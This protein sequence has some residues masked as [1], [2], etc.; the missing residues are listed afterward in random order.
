VNRIGSV[1]RLFTRVG[2]AL[3]FLV[4]LGI[5]IVAGCALSASEAL[6]EAL[7]GEKRHASKQTRDRR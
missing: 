7:I 5:G 2:N 4:I 3:A 1:R 6:E